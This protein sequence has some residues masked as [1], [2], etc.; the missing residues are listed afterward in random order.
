MPKE[1]PRT[2]PQRWLYARL[3]SRRSPRHYWCAA[4]FACL[5]A[6]AQTASQTDG[7]RHTPAP[8]PAFDLT[9]EAPWPAPYDSDIVWLRARRGD[10][11][12]HARLGRREG[13]RS[14][15]DAMAHAGSL[16]LTA[17]QALQHAPDRRDVRRDLCGLAT[18]AEGRTLQLLLEAVHEL[19]ME[20]PQNEEMVNPAADAACQ[21]VLDDIAG[22]PALNGSTRDLAIAASRHLAPR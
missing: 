9:T 14:L 17:L 11:L 7:E 4:A 3:R 18:R 15:L 19:L 21:Q 5:Q 10:D 1:T 12:E 13:A 8:P 16:G 2:G 6:C 20:A 22:R